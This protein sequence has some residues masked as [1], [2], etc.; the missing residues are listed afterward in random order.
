MKF[1]DDFNIIQLLT[2]KQKVSINEVNLL[3]YPIFGGASI[4]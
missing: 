1:I 2:K 3:S 4:G